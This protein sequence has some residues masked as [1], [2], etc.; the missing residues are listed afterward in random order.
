[1]PLKL[2]L[3]SALVSAVVCGGAAV[4][5][6]IGRDTGL[7]VTTAA[8]GAAGF[9]VG[10]CAAAVRNAAVGVYLRIIWTR[11]HHHVA[12]DVLDRMS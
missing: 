11:F 8:A 6:V 10:C 1:M 3:A 5:G 9:L 4:A 7:P 12:N 2:G